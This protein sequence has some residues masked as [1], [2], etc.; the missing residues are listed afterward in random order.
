MSAIEILESVAALLQPE[1]RERFLK[2]VVQL[3]NVPDDDEYLQILEAIG[4]MTLLWKEVPQQ[5]EK[6]LEKAS[7]VTETVQGVSSIVRDTV[8]EAIPSYDDLKA[9]SQRLEAHELALKNTLRT[10]A[11]SK[12]VGLRWP[13][14]FSVFNL[15]LIV[16]YIIHDLMVIRSYNSL[17]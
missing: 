15:G 2:M 16:G 17:F 13:W 10:S 6:T 12:G 9:I 8:V 14:I 11:K 1:K 5:I 4:F 7:P 3:R